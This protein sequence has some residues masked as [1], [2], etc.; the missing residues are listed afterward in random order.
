MDTRSVGLMYDKKRQLVWLQDGW[1][2]VYVA[3][4]FPETNGIRNNYDTQNILTVSPNPFNATTTV[5]VTLSASR[6]DAT[7]QVFDTQGKLVADLTS[8]LN[9]RT[10]RFNAEGLGAGL[11]IIKLNTGD[12]VYAKKLSFIE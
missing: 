5:N 4:L 2:G 3:R 6:T 1:S 12:A 9:E 8:L 10:I 7:L 11:Y